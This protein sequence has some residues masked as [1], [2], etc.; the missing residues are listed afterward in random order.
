PRG[1]FSPTPLMA[2]RPVQATG[3]QSY[4]MY[5]WH[6]PPLILL[7]EILGHEL[8]FWPRVG[9]LIGTF[10]LAWLTMK[11]VEDPIR[12]GTRWGM[13]RSGVTALASLTAAAVVVSVAT[14]GWQ[15]GRA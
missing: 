14:Y 1:W 10:A 11:C 13:Q 7:P 4:S 3:D 5:L 6:W 2:W 9:I 8:G 12:F 15:S